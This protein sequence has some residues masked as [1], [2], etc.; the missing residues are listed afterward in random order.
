MAL[1]GNSAHASLPYQA[2]GAAQGLEDALALLNVLAEIAQ[3]SGNSINT[4]EL[5][6][7][8]LYSHG[9]VRRLRA[10]KQ[11]EQA[12][13]VSRTMFLKHEEGGDDM[14]KILPRLQ[15]GR[16][17][18]LWFHDI[19]G[20]VDEALSGMRNLTHEARPIRAAMVYHL[21]KLNF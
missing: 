12:A 11:L 15:Q 1:L 19:Q 4:R 14:S 18:W 8:G 17:E 21:F 7:A 2:T 5:I 16:F 20:D 3:A 13:E 6:V 9:A 10:Q